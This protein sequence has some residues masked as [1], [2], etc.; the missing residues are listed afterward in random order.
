MRNWGGGL[1]SLVMM[2]LLVSQ[3]RS[4]YHQQATAVMLSGR[5]QK[6]L[7][8]NH[9]SNT[10]IRS[11][12]KWVMMPFLL[13]P[14]QL[15]IGEK[16]SCRK[17]ATVSNLICKVFGHKESVVWEFNKYTG[18]FI[19]PQTTDPLCPKTLQI[20]FD[21]VAPFLQDFFSPIKSCFG[22]NKKAS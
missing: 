16:K 1:F 17:G 5:N 15:L 14:K 11:S 10:G 3:T 13:A 2:R 7:K 6:A 4:V 19:E 21:T 8:S 12:S 9:F 20:R 22:T 18:V